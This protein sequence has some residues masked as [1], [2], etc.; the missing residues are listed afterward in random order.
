L[1]RPRSYAAEGLSKPKASG[2]F[3]SENDDGRRKHGWVN[4]KAP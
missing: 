3:P 4:E 1:A 2:T